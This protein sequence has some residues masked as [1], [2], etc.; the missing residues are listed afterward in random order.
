MREKSPIESELHNT[1]TDSYG[2]EG[3]ALAALYAMMERPE[4][5]A[6][7]ACRGKGL[8]ETNPWYPTKDRNTRFNIIYAQKICRDCPVRQECRDYAVDKA[9]EFGIW[10]GIGKD[11]RYQARREEGKVRRSGL[12]DPVHGTV[13]GYRQH[14][15]RGEQACVACLEANALHNKRWK[16]ARKKKRL[17]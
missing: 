7:A 4:W 5:H 16:E 14:R 11:A 13:T 2:D 6:R 15:R 1:T 12:G 9:E 3:A 8:G 10:A 17:A